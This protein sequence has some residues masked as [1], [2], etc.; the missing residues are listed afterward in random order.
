MADPLGPSL[1]ASGHT[2]PGGADPGRLLKGGRSG[3]E[4]GSRDDLK[5]LGWLGP[6]GS[7]EWEQIVSRRRD[8][9]P[10]QDFKGESRTEAWGIFPGGSVTEKPPCK[11]GNT[12]SVL[13]GV[14]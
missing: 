9:D 5:I 7:R 1:H 12:G 14:A 10:N 2:R 8:K 13:G 11:A 6:R 3:T 4:A